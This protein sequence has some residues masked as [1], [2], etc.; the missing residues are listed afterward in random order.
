M[1]MTRVR[2]SPRAFYWLRSC[3]PLRLIQLH[4]GDC[5]S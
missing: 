1:M 2:S 3:A 4:N 5:Q